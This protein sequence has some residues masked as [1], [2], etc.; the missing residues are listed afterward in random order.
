MNIGLLIRLICLILFL[1]ISKKKQSVMRASV[2]QLLRPIQYTL[3]QPIMM[4]P[5][6]EMMRIYF[7]RHHQQPFQYQRL[8]LDQ[9][10]VNI[11]NFH[12]LT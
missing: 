2:S 12:F 5:T 11:Y 7:V 10:Q 8:N 9:I 6:I 3:K 1:F 4:I